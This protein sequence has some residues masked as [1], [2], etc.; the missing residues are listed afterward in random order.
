MGAV[1]KSTAGLC[2]AGAAGAGAWGAGAD[3]ADAVIYNLVTSASSVTKYKDG[4]YSVTSISCTRW[5]SAGS[6][7]S[8]TQDGELKYSLDGGA[9]QTVNNGQSISSSSFSKSV[10]FLFYVDGNLVDVETIPMLA[11]AKDGESAVSAT[12]TNEMVNCALTADGKV[13][14]DQAWTTQVTQWYGTEKLP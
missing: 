5:K 13:S 11:E 8:A 9:E 14:K 1:A 10:K 12:I 4:T 7:L 6:N 2:C 3:G